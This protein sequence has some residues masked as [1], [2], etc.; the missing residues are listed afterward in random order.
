M[1]DM[2]NRCNTLLTATKERNRDGGIHND[3]VQ[4]QYY[5]EARIHSRNDVIISHD[6]FSVGLVQ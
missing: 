6:L 3:T 1:V 2:L 4:R 5:Q